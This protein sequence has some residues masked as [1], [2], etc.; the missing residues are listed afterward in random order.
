MLA[1]VME[2]DD[3]MNGWNKVMNAWELSW[4]CWEVSLNSLLDHH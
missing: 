1:R 4:L 3:T 2:Y